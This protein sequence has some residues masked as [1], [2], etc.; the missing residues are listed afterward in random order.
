MS[1]TIMVCPAIKMDYSGLVR[2]CG[3][4]EKN[5]IFC[6]ESDAAGHYICAVLVVGF[7]N[8]VGVCMCV[9]THKYFFSLTHCVFC[10]LL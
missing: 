7:D 3:I 4:S 6:C 2:S 9:Q 8:S 10:F 5:S 1:D